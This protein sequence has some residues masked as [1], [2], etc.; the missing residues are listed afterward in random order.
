MP[1]VKHM[2]VKV[3]NRNWV[4]PNFQRE[5][6]WTADQIVN[7]LD[8]M[9]RGYPIGA[10]ILLKFRKGYPFQARGLDGIEGAGQ[11][12]EYYIIDGQ[13]RLTS[14]Y[15]ILK[16]YPDQI[17][18]GDS[19][20]EHYFAIRKTQQ[21]QGIQQNYAFFL[22]Y[23]TK[24]SE[25]YVYANREYKK[26]R[27]DVWMKENGYIPLEY[28]FSEKK[29]LDSYMKTHKIQSYKN[30]IEKFKKAINNYEL[31][32]NQC[33]AN[34]KM[35]EYR[36]VFTRLNNEGTKLSAF[37]ECASILSK[38][39]FN[40]HKKWR[41]V[42]YNLK[43]SPIANLDIDPMYILKTMFIIGQIKDNIINIQSPSLKNL[44][45]YFNSSNFTEINVLWKDSV[46]YVNSA[47]KHFTEF[48][49]VRDRRLIPY[50]PMIVTLAGVL[51]SFERHPR[52]GRYMKKFRK[53]IDWWY[54]SSIF[55]EQ[56]KKAT[57]NKVATHV[58]KLVKWTHPT[59]S[60]N[61]KWADHRI[62][63]KRLSTIVEWLHIKTDARYR[64]ILCLSLV[65]SKTDILDNTIDDFEDH[66]YFT[67]KDLN[68][69]ELSANQIH[70]I[71]NKMAID[72]KSNR[73]IGNIS[74]NKY[75]ENKITISKKH[76]RLF[77]IPSIDSDM[78]EITKKYYL[79]FLRQRRK[80]IIQRIEEVTKRVQ[81]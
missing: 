11:K 30:E 7:L 54:W 36:T 23:N 61:S 46:K 72:K 17:F 31:T 49:G 50:A 8:S 75:R 52:H 16:E 78:K 28:V 14:L 45:K 4:L 18:K 57:D 47:C 48:Y 3:C 21:D 32:I 77:M 5:F 67:Q 12:N 64:G 9:R 43:F 19:F 22:K 73:T 53:R 79:S 33:D 15:K 24:S 42:S 6:I 13:Q 2:L 29:I 66:H 81:N 65:A 40:L 60:E 68:A 76:I 10:I 56:Y 1:N 41:E 69:L 62:D 39:K 26:M 34:W 37:D 35:D 80:L 25:Q 38:H 63:R 70:N 44:K 58:R 27:P 55:S 20:R 59:K 71:A 51:Y 74:P